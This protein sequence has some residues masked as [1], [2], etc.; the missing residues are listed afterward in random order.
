MEMAKSWD[1][2]LDCHCRVFAR[3]VNVCPCPTTLLSAISSKKESNRCKKYTN[4]AILYCIQLYLPQ[5]STSADPLQ[6]EG[7]KVVW[8]GLGFPMILVIQYQ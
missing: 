2:K 8:P 1:C 6:E 4:T 5:T 3:M 7:W